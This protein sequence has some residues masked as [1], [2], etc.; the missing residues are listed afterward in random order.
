MRARTQVFGWVGGA[1]C[2][3]ALAVPAQAQTYAIQGGTIHTLTGESYVGTVVVR[4][5]RI[6]A[7][8]PNVQA[9]DGAELVDA[10]GQHVYP[11]MFDAVSQLG[12]TEVGAVDMTNDSQEQGSYKPHLQAATA[13][14]PATEHIPVARANGIT[15]TIAVPSGGIISG[16]GSLVGLDG[17][18]VEE[19]NIDPGAAMVINFPS[20]QTRRG[21]GGR[22]FGAPR[23]FSEL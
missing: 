7:V 23:P 18:T 12:L 6:E 17:W 20:M 14:H 4:D 3:L 10:T 5:G 8:G 9:P 13:I 2:A 22:F 16:Q 11:G 1:M 21:F 19:M 15:H